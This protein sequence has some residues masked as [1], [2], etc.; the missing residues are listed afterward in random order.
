MTRKEKLRQILTK[1]NYTADAGP[2]PLFQL[3]SPYILYQKLAPGSP[4]RSD[5]PEAGVNPGYVERCIQIAVQLYERLSLG[6]RLLVVYEDIYGENRQEEIAFVESCLGEE[7][8][9][10]IIEFVWR[11]PIHEGNFRDSLTIK[12]DS[13]T[14][15]RCLYEA[16]QLDIKRLFR[17]II[18]SDIGG[19]YGLASK[20]YLAA[21]DSACIF[22]LYDD[23][24]IALYAPEDSPLSKVGAEH[25][26]VPEGEYIFSI[27]T[28]PF[29]WLNGS[30]DDPQDLCLHG[31]V[32]VTI[33]AEKF[34]YPCA[35]S[36][37]ALRMLR[38]LTE[39]HEP[40]RGEQMLPCCGHSLYANEALD[41]VTISG[42]DYGL[43]WAVRHEGENIRLVTVSGRE[44]IVSSTFYRQEVCRLADAVEDFYLN[45]S[46][47]QIAPEN[48][49]DRDGY[50]AFWNE[51]RR[52]REDAGA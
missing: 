44:I 19:R 50:T 43:D 17:E 42:C 16:K 24:G 48:A 5:D 31:L 2:I 3:A 4:Y 30:A 26:D 27:H 9:G 33:G 28:E 23:R 21:M 52:R 8:Q 34:S 37:A 41:E 12:E 38:T 22:H 35:V 13:Y 14:C 51:W 32:L 49:L 10:E 6:E 1:H 36:A 18:L 40:A 15:I 25:D 20:V 11:D 46:P 45:S 29:H 47:K 7:Q 39:N